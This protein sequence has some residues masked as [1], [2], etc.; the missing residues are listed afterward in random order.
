M[1]E[2]RRSRCYHGGCTR[3]D[4]SCPCLPADRQMTG[5]KNGAQN[6]SYDRHKQKINVHAMLS[7]RHDD[8]FVSRSFIEEAYVR[9]AGASYLLHLFARHPAGRIISFATTAAA[10]GA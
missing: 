3:F 9:F 2:E 6:S 1:V 5:W 7:I 8:D 10:V 4:R